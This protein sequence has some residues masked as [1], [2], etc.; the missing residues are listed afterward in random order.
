MD[1]IAFLNNPVRGCCDN[2]AVVFAACDHY[3][4]THCLCAQFVRNAVA[5]LGDLRFCK[6]GTQNTQHTFK[7]AVAD[8]AAFFYQ[9]HFQHGFFIFYL[10][11]LF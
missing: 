9:P 11:V 7:H 3:L 1:D 8:P 6:T 10:I 4:K 2:G 5:P